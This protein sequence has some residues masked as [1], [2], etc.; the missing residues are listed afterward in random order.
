MKK[1]KK[2]FFLDLKKD[3]EKA[4]YDK[5]TENGILQFIDDIINKKIQ[6]RAHPNKKNS[7]QG[8][9]FQARTL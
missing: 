2:S 4:N 9:Y 5:E 6:V 1:Q 7:R 3:I 8:V